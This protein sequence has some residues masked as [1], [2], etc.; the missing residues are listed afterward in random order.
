[1]KSAFGTLDKKVPSNPKYAGV[2]SKLDTGASANK[3]PVVSTSSAARRRD[4]IFKRIRAATLVRM[5]QETDVPE[6]VYNMGS[7]N[8]AEGDGVS[9]SAMSSK[10]FQANPP[11]SV[12]ASVASV[13]SV[14]S[15]I[16][17]IETDTTVDEARDLVLVDLRDPAE[18][19]RCHIPLAMSYPACYINRDQFPPE[20]HRCKRD[21]SKRLV[22]YHAND[23]ATSGVATLL[24]QKGWDQVHALS[25]GFEEMVQSYPEVLEGDVPDRPHTGATTRSSGTTA[26]RAA[27]KPRA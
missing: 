9:V 12:A 14:G 20:L 25:G 7:P 26:S 10:P 2:S 18:Y 19:E 16:S 17:V 24:V 22:V 27:A 4:E 1:M 15:V 5:I 21:S 3:Q 8:K 13:G 6:S 23:E 11:K